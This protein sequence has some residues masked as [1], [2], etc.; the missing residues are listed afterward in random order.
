MTSLGEA[1]PGNTP[2]GDTGPIGEVGQVGV[3]LGG[4]LALLI[5]ALL[6]A[7]LRVLAL[8]LALVVPG[9]AVCTAA[10]GPARPDSWPTRLMLWVTTSL[11]STAIVGLLV[12]LPQR[13]LTRATVLVAQA[14]V[15]LGSVVWLVRSPAYREHE[16][17][18]Q[19]LPYRSSVRPTIVAGAGALAIAVAALTVYLQVNRP[20][21]E[22]TTARIDGIEPEAPLAF[23]ADG[24]IRLPLVVV[25]E[26]ATARTYRLDPG[27]DGVPERW[28]PVEVRIESGDRWTGEVGGS[29]P[30]SGCLQRIGVTVTEDGVPSETGPISRWV[31]PK[32]GVLCVRHPT[33]TTTP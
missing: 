28:A 26:T 21:I 22:F 32:P 6:P 24:Q 7:P 31:A 2:P 17:A 10:I 4:G 5:T 27:V 16:L 20:A 1:P 15:V 12:A 29:I 23:P 25:N 30:V 9:Y 19:P 11:V 8:P 33:T 18:G 3:L 14:I 13:E